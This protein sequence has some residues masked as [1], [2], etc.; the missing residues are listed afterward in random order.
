MLAARG[1]VGLVLLGL[2]IYCIIDVVTTEESA[3]RHL[4]KLLWLAIVF[5]LPDIGSIIWLVAGRPQKA[6]FRIGDLGYRPSKAPLGVEDQPNF[7]V[8]MDD[9]SPIVRDREERAQ[10]HLRDEQLRRKEEDMARKERDAELKRREAD[11]LRR[12][13]ELRDRQMSSDEPPPPDKPD[14]P[15]LDG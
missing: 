5:F 3:V 14:P 13:R 9:L 10:A 15:K 1:A 7:G 12:E 8:A 2:W 11:L 4:P 6:S